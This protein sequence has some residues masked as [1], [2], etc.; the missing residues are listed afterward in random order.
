MEEV[1]IVP[2]VSKHAVK[3]GT[4][5]FAATDESDFLTVQ[6]DVVAGEKP[7]NG[8]G[9]GGVEFCVL[10][11]TIDIFFGSDEVAECV[12]LGFI[13]ERELDDDTVN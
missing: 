9:S 6:F 10:S 3:W 12:G 8:S 1:D 5:E 4:D 7:I 2:R 11:K 13:G